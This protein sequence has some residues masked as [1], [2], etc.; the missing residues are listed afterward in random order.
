MTIECKLES[1]L[2][3][4]YKALE[5]ACPKKWSKQKFKNP[6]W[7]DDNLTHMR[8]KLTLIWASGHNN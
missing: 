4:L 5:F 3:E 8:S 2:T 1:F 6:T 7:W